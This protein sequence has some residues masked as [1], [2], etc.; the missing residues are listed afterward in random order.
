MAL[1]YRT[2]FLSNIFEILQF[3]KAGNVYINFKQVKYINCSITNI[4]RI[5]CSRNTIVR[6]RTN[7][8]KRLHYQIILFNTPKFLFV[9]YFFFYAYLAKLPQ[10][11]DFIYPYPLDIQR[12]T[13][14][15]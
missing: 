3:I 11:K 5:T 4:S 1:F 8:K 10:R 2:N 6:L 7:L 14:Y 15:N 13:G 9:S 12:I